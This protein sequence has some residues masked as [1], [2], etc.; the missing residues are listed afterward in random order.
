[1]SCGGYLAKETK[2][3]RELG[4]CQMVPTNSGIFHV[5]RETQVIR[6]AN[7]QC[8]PLDFAGSQEQSR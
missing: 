8:T 2:K 6:V 7:S 5:N 4:R 3:W 1:M